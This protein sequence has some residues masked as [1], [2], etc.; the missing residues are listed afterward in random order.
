MVPQITASCTAVQAYLT[1]TVVVLPP[2]VAAADNAL[3]YAARPICIIRLHSYAAVAVY[4]LRSFPKVLSLRTHSDNVDVI[5]IELLQ[6]LVPLMYIR[7]YN[8]G[9]ENVSRFLTCNGF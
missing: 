2:C 7:Q 6:T 3:L 5:L 9:A 1:V 8:R 4:L